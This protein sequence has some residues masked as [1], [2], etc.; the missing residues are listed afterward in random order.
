[1]SSIIV[2][3][4]GINGVVA[5][6]ELNQ[7]GH[8]VTLI[9][10][11]PVPH[12]LAASTDISKAVR[13]SYGADEDYTEMAERSVARWREWN[14]LFGTTLYHET[15]AMFLRQDPMKP[16]DFEYETLRLLTSRGHQVERMTPAC[17]RERFP[18]WDSERFQD[19]V[20]DPE[21]GYAESGRT[22]SELLKRARSLGVE[23]REGAAF[24]EL[25]QTA[26]GDVNGIVLQDG[27]RLGAEAVLAATGAWTPYALP[28]TRHF[29]RATGHPV[30]HL[31]PN[32]PTLFM[33]ERFPMFGADITNTGYYGFPVGREGVVKIGSHGPGR[34][35][36]GPDADERTVTVDEKEDLRAF[37]ALAFPA[38]TNAPI[39]DTRLCLYCDTNDGDFW[40]A[41]DP[42][43]PGLFIAAGDNGHGFKFAPVLGEL[44]ADAIERKENRLLEKFRWRPDVRA[45][46]AHEAAR[47]VPRK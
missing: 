37:I 10:P 5:A 26:G 41:A 46:E 38:L 6:I 45:G 23:V 11:G 18:A 30:F 1:M 42:E 8:R 3:G 32:D 2:I 17:L 40:I 4:A 36:S 12:P 24:R 29:F 21:G 9:D 22:V 34:E 39:V 15:G 19:G 25:E 7:R 14:N 28:F 27:S 43:R 16:G 20:F 13:S 33:P 44:I 31:R 47:F 35:V